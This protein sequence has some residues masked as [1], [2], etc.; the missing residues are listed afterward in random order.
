MTSDTRTCLTLGKA[1]FVCITQRL[2]V[3]SGPPHYRG[4]TITPRLTT[5]G[6]PPS[7]ELSVRHGD[8]NLTTHNTHKRQASMILAE[9]QPAF[10]GSERPQTHALDRKT[11]GINKGKHWRELYLIAQFYRAV[12]TLRFSYENKSVSVVQG[13]NRC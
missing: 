3:G 9:F 1:I 4:F 6:R 13:S 12:N 10:P 5:L 2:L 11:A 7:D 8:L